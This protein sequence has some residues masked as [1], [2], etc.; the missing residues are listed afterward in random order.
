[1]K[2]TLKKNN[3]SRNKTN[4]IIRNTMIKMNSEDPYILSRNIINNFNSPRLY[5]TNSKNS[6]NNN[7]IHSIEK[8]ANLTKEFSIDDTSKYLMSNYMY[9]SPNI[10]TP[11]STRFEDFMSKTK[12]KFF[13]NQKQEVSNIIY[14]SRKKN[15]TEDIT[16][17]NFDNNTTE[18][19]NPIDS[20]GLILNNKC[21]Y[22]NIMKKFC[23]KTLK[24]F[25]KTLNK[26]NSLQEL[27][28]LN[29]KKIK[30]TSIIPRALLDEKKKQEYIMIV[31]KKSQM[32]II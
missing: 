31:K 18:Y 3:I 1:M 28:N 27:K 7:L 19:K 8:F 16:K 4:E 14:K 10:I 6:E 32:K 23:N 9:S 13:K 12:K 21:I 30:I 11:N 5:L 20:L 25:G 17:I 15:L 22:D 24:S 29:E 26:F 2:F